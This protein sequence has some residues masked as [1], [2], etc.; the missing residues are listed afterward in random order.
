MDRI[1]NLTPEQAQRSLLNLFELLPEGWWQ[2][3]KPT[4]FDIKELAGEAPEYIAALENQDEAAR[5]ELAREI[6]RRFAEVDAA[7]PLVDEAI[8]K[9]LAARLA[10]LPLLIVPML[11]VLMGVEIN[12]PSGTSLLRIGT[13]GSGAD[14]V[15][16][17]AQFARA[18]P[19][20]AWSWLTQLKRGTA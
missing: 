2:D 18:L 20:G 13:P 1:A 17:L 7:R 14:L 8:G 15:K 11:I 4:P 19:S 9:S 5:G 10:P 12:T 16:S 6:L 3:G